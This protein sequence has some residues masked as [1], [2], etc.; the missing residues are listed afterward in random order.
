[1]DEF[2]EGIARTRASRFRA[3]DNLA[4]EYLYPHWMVETWHARPATR[5]EA[6]RV[7]GFAS[8]ENVT[9]W[10]WAQLRR[11]DWRRPV[12]ATLNDSFGTRPNPRV[13]RLVR[14]WLERQFPRP[15]RFERTA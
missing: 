13:E 15:S 12:T 14:G 9:P 3:G 2:A 4:P 1:M 11:I 6:A 5:A 8:L 10:T 7:E